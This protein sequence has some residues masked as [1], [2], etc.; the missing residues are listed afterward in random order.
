MRQTVLL[1]ALALC[2][3][4]YARQLQAIPGDLARTAGFTPVTLT[5][6]RLGCATP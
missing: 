5:E 2:A 1:L 6:V 3:S 4:A